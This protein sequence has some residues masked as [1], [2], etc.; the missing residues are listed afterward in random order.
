LSPGACRVPISPK[1]TSGLKRRRHLTVEEFLSRWLADVRPSLRPRTWERYEQYARLHAVPS[2]GRIRLSALG[3]DDVQHLYAERLAAGCSP[4]TVLHLHRFL[5]RALDRAVRR[6]LVA[7]NVTDLVDP[8]RMA[9]A[10]FDTL[11]VEEVRRL[12]AAAAGDRLE[13]LYVL[14][15]TTGLREGELLALRWSDVDLESGSLRVRGSLQP[16][17]GRGLVTLEPKTPRSRRQVVLPRVAVE[18][19]VRHRRAQDGERRAAGARWRDLGLA[20]PNTVGRPM[21][22]QNLLQRSFHPLLERAGLARIRF[23]DLRHTTATLLLGR[24]VHPRIVQDRLGHSSVGVTLD[25]YSH[26]TPTMQRIAADAFDELLSPMEAR[27]ADGGL[28]GSPP[29]GAT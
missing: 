24:N 8:P 25:T 1:R 20:F 26:V 23:H 11:S 27:E 16:V 4:T 13:A 10:E 7:R 28:P 22:A 9:R 5:H 6:G 19:L 3:P 12:L 17:R 2:I 21:S 14:A 18:A 29:R 15:V